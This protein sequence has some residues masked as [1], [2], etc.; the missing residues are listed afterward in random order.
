MAKDIS[1]VLTALVTPFDS[2]D[3]I[4]VPTLQ[5]VVDRSVDGGVDG[6]VVAGST[7]EVGTMT[8]DE[9]LQLV[10][11]VVEHTA[12]RLPVIAQTGATSTKQA[13]R[14]SQA[15]QKA[16]ADVLM[17]VTPFYEP[18]TV[19][20]TCAYLKDVAA[21]VDLPIMLYNIPAA[22]GVN[23]DPETVRQ[24]A[25]EVDN[26]Q[27]V[28]DSSADYEQALHL[29]HHHGDVIK[30]FIGWDVYLY[31]A[32]VEG[33]TGVLA[34][35]GNVIPAELAAVVRLIRSGDLVAAREQWTT[36]YPVLDAMLSAPFIQAVKVGLELQGLPVG[37]PRAPLAAL[38]AEDRTRLEAAL[39]TLR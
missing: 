26:I 34:G 12:G 11:V 9:R 13:I 16:G 30:T 10:D 29:I 22:T 38:P 24:L 32:L 4:D 17:L 3:N 39:A 25:T 7:G 14:L 33:A 36:V 28:K 37:G 21:A 19:E 35:T 1:G 6:I 18:I 23:L 27:Y 5:R 8:F 20:E 2:D 31:S 15:A